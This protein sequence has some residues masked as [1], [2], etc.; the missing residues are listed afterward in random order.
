MMFVIELSKRASIFLEKLDKHIM[1]IITTR[2]KKLKSNPFPKD[3]KFLG[4]HKGDKVFR[5]R[6]GNYRAL[7][8]VKDKIVLITK[9]DK[10]E[11]IYNF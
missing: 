11:R 6:I 8:K 1:E 4:R 3:A 10:R 2:L 9:I 7:Y 5:Y